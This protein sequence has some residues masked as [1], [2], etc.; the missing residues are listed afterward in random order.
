V[1]N[2]VFASWAD[3]RTAL[4]EAAAAELLFDCGGTEI[5]LPQKAHKHHVVTR[6][7]GLDGL[8]R[9]IVK[10]GAGRLYLP[11]SKKRGA[12]GRRALVEALLLKGHSI[13]HAARIADVSQ[14]TAERVSARM[15]ECGTSRPAGQLPLFT[16]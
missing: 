13:A 8:K 1:S 15:R 10:Y 7:A 12:A 16:S 5:F 3:L 14:A 11:Q 2:K 6:F 4:G 9:L